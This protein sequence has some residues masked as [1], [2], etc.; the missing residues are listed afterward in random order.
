MRVVEI[1]ISYILLKIFLDIYILFSSWRRKI[2][3]DKPM[4]DFPYKYNLLLKN[5]YFRKSSVTEDYQ[6]ILIVC[7]LNWNCNSYI[8]CAPDWAF[9]PKIF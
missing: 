9:G 5:N 2:Q 1:K 7:V 4:K 8:V 6:I 3:E